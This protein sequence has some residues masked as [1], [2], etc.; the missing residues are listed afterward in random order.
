[1]FCEALVLSVQ[2]N[3]NFGQNL[4]TCRSPEKLLAVVKG[5]SF[6]NQGCQMVYFQTKNPTLGKF[7]RVLHRAIE[8][9]G[10]FYGHLP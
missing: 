9:V 7:L 3:H 10:I 5:S 1:V 4:E 8:D 6:S 2:R